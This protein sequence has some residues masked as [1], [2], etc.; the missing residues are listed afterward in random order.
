LISLKLRFTLDGNFAAVTLGSWEELWMD[1]LEL[2]ERAPYGPAALKAISQAFDA[3]W[4]EVAANYGDDPGDIAVGRIRLARAVLAVADESSGDTDALKLAA[5]T[6]LA[7][8]Y[9]KPSGGIGY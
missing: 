5:L 9:R 1:A 3:A 8:D 2:I 6:R 7:L 4:A